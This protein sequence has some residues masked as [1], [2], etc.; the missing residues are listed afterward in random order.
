MELTRTD[1]GTLYIFGDKT[2]MTRCPPRHPL[3]HRFAPEEGRVVLKDAFGKVYE[4]RSQSMFPISC[5]SALC[6]EG[7]LSQWRHCDTCGNFDLCLPCYEQWQN[8][9]YM[10]H[11]HEMTLKTAEVPPVTQQPGKVSED[12]D[13]PPYVEPTGAAALRRGAS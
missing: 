6:W 4:L 2:E 5:D 10:K 7:G 11:E 3:P 1:D 9:R 13:P 12:S 8:N